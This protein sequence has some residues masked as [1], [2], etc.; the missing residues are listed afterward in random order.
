MDTIVNS[1]NDNRV[2][3]QSTTYIH[4]HNKK[5][6]KHKLNENIQYNVWIPIVNE[7]KW[8]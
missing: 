2:H 7:K 4:S 3:T 6:K 1:A 5:R 8:D